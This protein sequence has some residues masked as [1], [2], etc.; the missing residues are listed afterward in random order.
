MTNLKTANTIRRTIITLSTVAVVALGA[1]SARAEGY[2][3]QPDPG[4]DLAIGLLTAIAGGVI[5]S[6]QQQQQQQYEPVEEEY[7]EPG[8]NYQQ[9][10]V[11]QAHMNWCLN[12]FRSYDPGSDTYMGFDGHR[13]YCNSPYN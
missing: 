6:L 10:N 12:R 3:E 1:A 11:G 4:R 9:I 5:N 2:E 13:H 8:Q 7:E